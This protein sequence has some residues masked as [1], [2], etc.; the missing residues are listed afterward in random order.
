VNTATIPYGS[1]RGAST[2]AA[3]DPDTV[4]RETFAEGGN[5]VDSTSPFQDRERHEPLIEFRSKKR[6]V[7]R[8]ASGTGLADPPPEFAMATAS[9]VN[10]SMTLLEWG[11]LLTLSVLWGG[12]FFFVGV[13]VKELPPLTIMTLRVALAALALHIIIGMMGVRMP[14][15][16]RSVDRVL[17]QRGFE[18]APQGV[19]DGD[20]L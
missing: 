5:E 19:A 1:C 8:Y 13:A 10:R 20:G 15:D 7:A 9:T 18:N 17:R 14:P 2:I 12:S 6:L 11:L 4:L 16:A 3:L